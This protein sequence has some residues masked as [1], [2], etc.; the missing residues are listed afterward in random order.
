M[1]ARDSIDLILW[2]V[3]LSTFIFC[4]GVDL[5][6]SKSNSI[7]Y[8]LLFERESI[9]AFATRVGPWVSTY[10][11]EGQKMEL[12]SKL[13]YANHPYG[14]KTESFLGLQ[15]M[16]TIAGFILSLFLT[17][18]GMPVI[19]FFILV[20]IGFFLPIG[21]LN[22]KA[23]KRQTAIRKDLPY[24][25]GLLA[26]AVKAGVE[27]APAFGLIAQNIPGI[28]G[29]ELRIT[30][31]EIDT[32]SARVTALKRLAGRCGVD[33]LDRF[34]ETIN[35]AE[36]RGGMNLSKVLED[37]TSDVRVM[38]KLVMEERA[39]KLPTK[40]LAP[41]VICIFIPMLAILLTPIAY[42]LVINL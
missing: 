21:M 32:G 22:E 30:T 10:V 38:Q 28:L 13:V 3:F 36:E 31:Q 7:A 15:A 9:Y 1:A 40:M 5:F 42:T 41:I 19:V 25:V 2:L 12:T 17:S 20:P 8:K 24:M 29:N 23:E 39:K 11:P 37:F 34:V 6:I 4:V 33:T 27:F 35:T 16:L 26:T 18:L 14:L